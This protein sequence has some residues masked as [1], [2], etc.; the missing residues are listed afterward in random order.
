MKT[1]N[2]ILLSLILPLAALA[3]EQKP[4]TVGDLDKY[5]KQMVSYTVQ[6][7]DT[8]FK[9]DMYT[10]VIVADLTFKNPKDKQK[11]DKL[12][13]DVKKAYPYALLAKAKLQEYDNQLALIKGENERKAFAEKAE[14]ELIKQFEKD[15]RNLTRSQGKILCKLIDRETERTTYT[16]VKQYRGSFAAVMWQGVARIFG[17]NL[18][19]DYDP[20]GDERTIEHIVGLI[21]MGVI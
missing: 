17:G 3:Q 2:A 18:K 8:T 13:R 14:K 19:D 21:D 12:K 9:L 7:G 10:T 11:Y 5:P 16:I 4:L 6:N 20:N 15:M 1:V